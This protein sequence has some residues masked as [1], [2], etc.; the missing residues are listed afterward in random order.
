MKQI[1]FLTIFAICLALALFSLENTTPTSIQIV[2]GVQITA[3]LSIELILAMGL[4][5]VFAWIYSIWTRFLQQLS[6]SQSQRQISQKEQQIEELQT[7]IAQYQAEL[8]QKP[9]LPATDSSQ[10]LAEGSQ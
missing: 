3:P 1:N 6:R 2:E 9:Q 10:L 5:A 8:A 4:G 7:T